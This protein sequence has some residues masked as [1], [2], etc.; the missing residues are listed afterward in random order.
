[1]RDSE[2]T[3][4]LRRLLG[5]G[6]EGKALVKWYRCGLTGS[7]T[8]KRDLCCDLGK[9]CQLKQE[10]QTIHCNQLLVKREYT[11]SR[12]TYYLSLNIRLYSQFKY[13]QK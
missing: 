10:L 6:T 4:A 13:I 5:H 11:F 1:M 12:I 8:S 2:E 7:Q 3:P 9:H